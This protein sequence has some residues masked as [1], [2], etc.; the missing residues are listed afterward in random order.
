MRR[1]DHEKAEKEKRIKKRME[2]REKNRLNTL[3]EEITTHILT[4][5]VQ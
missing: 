3:K 5:A 2:L 1:R 4:P